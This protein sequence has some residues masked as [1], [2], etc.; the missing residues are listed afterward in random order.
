VSLRIIRNYFFSN[1]SNEWMELHLSKYTRNLQEIEMAY[2]CLLIETGH[3]RIL[4]DTG[5]GSSKFVPVTANLV[6]NLRSESIE[7]E[8]IDTVILSHGHPDHI[9][10]N[11]DDEGRQV[12]P[13]ARYVMRKEE[14][15]YWMSPPDLE[16]LKLGQQF[17]DSIL[18]AA[19][20]NLSAIRNQLDLVDEKNPEI[21][22]G[23]EAVAT[24]G[25]TPGHM[26][27]DISSDAQRLLFTGDAFIH[28]LH[29]EHPETIA[30]VDHQPEKMIATRLQLL[31]KAAKEKFL[32]FAPHFP[33]PGLGHVAKKPNQWE[34]QPL[35]VS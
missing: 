2:T 14:W 8:E 33:F 30:L 11:L 22:P 21:L 10:G 16:E 9:G 5:M 17:K 32:V 3:N 6:K 7:P 34:W 25:H 28:P 18:N 19:R 12:F 1:V 29:I 27:I 23:I 13:N 15:D 4:I 31:E 26:S 35:P 24:S 20:R